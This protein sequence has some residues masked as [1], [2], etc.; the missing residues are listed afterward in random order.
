MQDFRDEV[1]DRMQERITFPVVMP[2]FSRKMTFTVVLAWTFGLSI[3]WKLSALQIASYVML[4]TYL[5]TRILTQR[6][7]YEDKVSLRYYM[8]CERS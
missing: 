6:S 1:G 4:G 8:V 7:E 3:F 5:A 2:E